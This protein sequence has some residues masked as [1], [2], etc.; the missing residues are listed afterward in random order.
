MARKGKKLKLYPTKIALLLILPSLALYL[1]FM[2]WPIVFSVYIAFTDA[3]YSNIAPN[4]DLLSDLKKAKACIV[5]ARS[6]EKEIAAKASE[7][8]TKIYYSKLTLENIHTELTYKLEN[9]ETIDYIYISSI[10]SKIQEADQNI[11]SAVAIIKNLI[12]CNTTYYKIIDPYIEGNLSSALLIL[13]SNVITQ[14]QQMSLGL[15]GEITSNKVIAVNN[16]LNRTL[17]WINNVLDSIEEMGKDF[18]GFIDRV[19]QDIDNRLYSLELHFVGLRNLIDLLHDSRFIYSMYKTLLFVATSVPIKVSVGVLLAF[20]F[21][22]P[23][24]YGRKIWRAL[25]LTPWAIPTLLSVTTWRILMSPDGPLGNMFSSLMNTR[26]TIYANEWHA[27]LTYNI[28]E[29]WLAY[30]FIMTVTMGAIAGI[31]REL[32]EAAYIDGASVWLRFRK[33]MLP[34]VIRPILFATVL[35]TGASLQAFMVPLLINGGGPEGRIVVDG[36]PPKIGRLNEFMVLF[37]YNRAYIDKE[38]G[39]AA[40]SYI[41]LVIF[42]AIYILI[43][44]KITKMGER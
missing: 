23:M 5:D 44:L 39:L 11:S 14:L 40:A 8:Y 25:L 32:I 21:S 43:W 42:L 29:M 10:L 30:P 35:T 28:V 4:P 27:F 18:T 41:F 2:L 17:Y 33:I 15:F 6:Y 9:N 19:T 7:A 16:D 37:G 1:F 22:T 24:I 38:Y 20:L 34:Q 26:F 3:T 13:E 36:L 31:P 12:P